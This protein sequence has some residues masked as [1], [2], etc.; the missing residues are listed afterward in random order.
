MVPSGADTILLKSTLHCCSDKDS[1]TIL[2]NCANS[3]PTNGRV[4]VMERVIPDNDCSHWSIPVDVTMLV[5]TGGR[6]RTLD[7]YRQ[8]YRLSGFTFVR[9]LPLPSGFSVLEGIRN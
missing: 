8:L 7:D 5:I 3:L 4:F 6:E 9:E 2:A 1:I